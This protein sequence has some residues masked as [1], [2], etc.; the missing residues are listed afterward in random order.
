MTKIKTGSDEM[1]KLLLGLL[2]VS[3]LFQGCAPVTR[4]HVITASVPQGAHYQKFIVHSN[5][6]DADNRK[7]IEDA[8]V[9]QLTAIGVS[10]TAS[11]SVFPPDTAYTWPEKK[12][13]IQADGFDAGL[14]VQVVDS[15]NKTQTQ[16][17][18]NHTAAD[19][20]TAHVKMQTKIVDTRVFKVVW[21]A[22]SSSLAQ[23]DDEGGVSLEDVMTSYATGLVTELQNEGVVAGTTN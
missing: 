22:K 11:Y 2:M 8:V 21:Q 15:Y 16:F 1:K 18:I 4:F 14:L 12:Q 5:L 20:T 23:T 19:F 13:M 7:T 3:P 10:A 9:Q 6:A 17:F